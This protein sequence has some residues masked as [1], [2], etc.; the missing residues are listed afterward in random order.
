L[1]QSI[2]SFSGF[3]DAIV[4]EHYEMDPDDTAA[5]I[6]A[7]IRKQLTT[8]ANASVSKLWR[9][10]DFPYKYVLNATVTVPATTYPAIPSV[11]LPA[12]WGGM[13]WQGAVH[14]AQ[15]APNGPGVVTWRRL[16]F[17]MDQLN[18]REEH[19]LVRHYSIQGAY[20]L[21]ALDRPEANTDLLVSYE[22][23]RP[24]FT[25][26]SPGGIDELPE[27]WIIP[28]LW[29]DTLWRQA[30][31]DGDLQAV[32]SLQ[33]EAREALYDVVCA[34]E[35]GKPDEMSFPRY[36]GSLNLAGDDY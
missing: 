5:S 26:A 22:K 28:F 18:Q 24:F 3:L 32:P 16:G 17:V 20:N 12:A 15:D 9:T 13:G 35:D 25:D 4:E 34:H 11:A 23:R 1:A 14:R 7:L 8:A 36:A 10:R 31:K 2:T 21:I 27:E 6:V 33:A 19:G 30:Q 29:P